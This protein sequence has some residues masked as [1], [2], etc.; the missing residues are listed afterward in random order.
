MMMALGYLLRARGKGK[1]MRMQASVVCV[2]GAI[3]RRPAARS[4]HERNRAF[5]ASAS[6]AS[7]R[8]KLGGK[9][10]GKS[11]LAERSKQITNASAAE[12][13]DASAAEGVAAA[14]S[15]MRMVSGEA[16]PCE[17]S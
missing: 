9:T 7:I 1:G 8:Q 13:A 6:R 5:A 15:V 14:V 10:R 4:L 12:H 3:P 11:N 16:D 17:R 2:L